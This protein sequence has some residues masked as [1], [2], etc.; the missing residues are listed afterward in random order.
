MIASLLRKEIRQH[1]PLL[2]ITAMGILGLFGVMYLG[3][4]LDEGVSH[5]FELLQRMAMIGAVILSMVVCNRLVVLEYQSKTQLFLEA[6]PLTRAWMVAMKY[7]FGAAYV[8]AICGMIFA[9]T[10]LL[11]VTFE[12]LTLRH[13]GIVAMRTFSFVLMVYT[14]FFMMGL[15]GRYRVAIY[16]LLFFCFAFYTQYTSRSASGVPILDLIMSSKFAYER[17]IIPW[18]QLAITWGVIGG[19]L[20]VLFSMALVREGSVASMLAEKMSYQEKVFISCLIL[21]ISFFIG[22]FVE[23]LESEPFELVG[24]IEASEGP[25]SVTVDGIVGEPTAGPIAERVVTAVS[26]FAEFFGY[27]TLPAAFVAFRS[28][29]DADKYEQGQSTDADSIVVRVNMSDEKWDENEFIAFLVRDL[30][31][32]QSKRLNYCEPKLWLSDGARFYWAAQAANPLVDVEQ[33]RLRAAYA[34]DCFDATCPDRWLQL[35]DKVGDDIVSAI[36]FVGLEYLAEEYGKED[37]HA[38]LRDVLSNRVPDDFR[39]VVHDSLNSMPG[40]MKKHFNT[41]Y[42]SFREE[43]VARVQKLAEE[44]AAELKS[45]PRIT[46]QVSFESISDESRSLTW[47]VELSPQTDVFELRYRRLEGFEPRSGKRRAESLRYPRDT[48]GEL[49]DTFTIGDRVRTTFSIRNDD[50]GCDIISGWQNLT[51]E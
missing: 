35:N 8:V 24:G 48:Q 40:L 28:D 11:A 21:G 6:L 44:R 9:I 3:S 27:E 20:T 30:Q 34:A 41:S 16:I 42:D 14:F 23:R 13:M 17:V 33:L 25:A 10:S 19:F 31:L 18:S 15:L 12:E 36:A 5:P 22:I 2:T 29:L 4:E 49:E 46:G 51:V 50:L 45:I 7:V 39:G 1:W 47:D 26:D 37:C 38:F 43:W 32:A